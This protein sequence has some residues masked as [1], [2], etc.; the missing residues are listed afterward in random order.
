MVRLQ[1]GTPISW[2]RIALYDFR[3]DPSADDFFFWVV[4]LLSSDD[5]SDMHISNRPKKEDT[6][7]GHLMFRFSSLK[8]DSSALSCLDAILTTPSLTHA[9]V[10]SLVVGHSFMYTSLLLLFIIL[11][12]LFHV[13]C[14]VC[15]S[16]V[17]HTIQFFFVDRAYVL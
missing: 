11:F 9:R 3:H 16:T 1:T 2:W 7:P 8:T 15:C 17:S 13:C 12:W 6:G 5:R 10:W 4:T 14:H